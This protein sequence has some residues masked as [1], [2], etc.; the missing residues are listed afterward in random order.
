MYQPEYIP[1]MKAGKFEQ[2]CFMLSITPHILS[3]NSLTL[4]INRLDNTRGINF[5]EQLQ[6]SKKRFRIGA[7]IYIG[8]NAQTNHAPFPYFQYV[9]PVKN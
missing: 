5:H 7:E 6:L 3:S 2:T 4:N 1:K 8:I 9:I